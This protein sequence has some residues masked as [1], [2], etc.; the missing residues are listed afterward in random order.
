MLV[1]IFHADVLLLLLLLM[2]LQLTCDQILS[3][4]A[5]ITRHSA[6]NETRETMVIQIKDDLCVYRLPLLFTLPVF[7]LNSGI[8]FYFLCAKEIS[9]IYLPFLDHEFLQ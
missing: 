4:C 5:L 7:I 8:N 6:K 2:V 9:S 3:I 1:R